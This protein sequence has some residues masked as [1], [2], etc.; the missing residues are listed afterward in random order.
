MLIAAAF[1]ILSTNLNPESW[2]LS[3]GGVSRTALVYRPSRGSGKAPIIICFHGHGGNSRYAARA[4]D[5]QTQWPEALVVYPQGLPTV[6]ARVDP[7]GKMPGWQMARLRGNADIE[8]FDALVAKATKEA[9]GDTSRVFIMGHSNGGGFVYTLWAARPDAI[10]GVASANA[11]GAMRV[12]RP[13]PA[14]I[15]VGDKDQ[16]VEPKLQHSSLDTVKALLGSTPEGGRKL[17]DTVHA[18]SGKAPLVTYIYDGGHDFQ[19]ASVPWMVKFFQSL[20]K[21]L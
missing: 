11:A 6:S 16:L 7:Q 17:S 20:P 3:V 19:K 10:A 8:L 18:Y 14:F 12:S 9:N 4:Y 2:S 13:L 21:G 5:F 15:V 1:V